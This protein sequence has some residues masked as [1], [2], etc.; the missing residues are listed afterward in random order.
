[1][2][3]YLDRVQAAATSARSPAVLGLIV[4]SHCSRSSSPTPSHRLQ[5]FANLL[6]Q[7]TAIIVLAMGMVFVLLLGEIDLSA[8]F[9]AGASA[10]V[11]AIVLSS[12]GFLAVHPRVRTP[13]RHGHRSDYRPARRA[14]GH[15]IVRHTLAM[16]LALQGV[17][18][19]PIIR[20]RRHHPLRRDEL[21]RGDELADLPVWAGWLLW[22]IVMLGYALVTLRAI[23]DG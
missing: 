16:F 8:G 10:A 3:G 9:A 15:P 1:M 19:L 23:R 2:R 7:G 18:L 12:G 13:H 6:N 4:S 17:M 5:C 14:P 20:R 22:G 21:A 11:L